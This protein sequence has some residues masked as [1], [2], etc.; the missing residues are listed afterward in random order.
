MSIY[1]EKCEIIQVYQKRTPF[2]FNYTLQGVLLE[3][4]PNTKYLG[5]FLSQDVKWNTHSH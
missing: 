1:P 3:T 4:V 2:M 5:L